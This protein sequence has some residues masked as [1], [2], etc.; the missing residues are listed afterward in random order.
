MGQAG[1]GTQNGGMMI[2]YRQISYIKPL[3][4][5]ILSQEDKNLESKLNQANNPSASP[6]KM[7][8]SSILAISFATLALAHPSIHPHSLKPRGG[9][10]YAYGSFQVPS[11]ATPAIPSR[12]PLPPVRQLGNAIVHNYCNFTVYLW[13]VGTDVQPVQTLPP[14]DLYIEQFHEDPKTGG[15]AIK[16]TTDPDGLYTSAPQMVFAYNLSYFK[17][18]GD[19]GEQ[20]WYDLSDVFGDPFQ[21]YPVTLRP[22]EPSIEWANGVPPAGSQVRVISSSTDLLLS[23]C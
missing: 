10:P 5:Q 3:I 4:F 7:Y 14:N 2:I 22:S 11:S 12:T 13:S 9:I 23:L 17:G 20:V 15:I 19:N 1:Q 16:L 21:G 6:R 8:I 18:R